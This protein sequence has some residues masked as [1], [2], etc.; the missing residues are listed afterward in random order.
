MYGLDYVTRLYRGKEIT[1]T[2]GGK[3]TDEEAKENY[4]NGYNSETFDENYRSSLIV[5]KQ[6]KGADS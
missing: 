5:R 2:R 1:L 6:R 3:F 4:T